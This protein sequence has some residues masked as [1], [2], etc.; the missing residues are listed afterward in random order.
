MD[1]ARSF[2]Q[3]GENS[4]LR[5]SVSLDSLKSIDPQ[6]LVSLVQD[7]RNYQHRMFYY[8]KDWQMQSVFE[9]NYPVET[10]LKAY[11]EAKTYTEKEP[12]IKS[13]LPIMTWYKPNLFYWAKVGYD[14][15]LDAA[16]EMYNSYFGS[17]LS[18]IVFQELRESRSLWHTLHFRSTHKLPIT[19]PQTTCTIILVPSQ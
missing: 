2:A 14:P 7:I 3:Y 18:S 6:D 13:I 16:T 8:G 9:A 11:P 15:Q 4:R 5:N 12:V 19:K 17:G 10:P 1:G